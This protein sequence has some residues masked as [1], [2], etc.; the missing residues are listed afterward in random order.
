MSPRRRNSSRRGWPANLYERRGY[1]SWRNPITREEFGLGRDR[2]SAFA[3]AIEANLHIA[4]L[5]KKERLVD[6]LVSG[7]KKRTLGVWLERY[8]EILAERKLA[9]NTRRHYRSLA[10]RA[11]EI[12][13]ADTKLRAIT[14]L[15]VSEA[16][17]ALAKD[18]PRMAQ[19]LRS[20]LHES[21]REAVVQG[22]LDDNPVRTVRGPAVE[23]RRARLEFPV[24]MAV[25]ERTQTAWLRNAMAL[26]LVS[27]QRREDIALAEFADVHDGAW[28]V[29]QGKTGARIAIPLE[30]RLDVFGMSL[31]DVIRQCRRTGVVSPYLIHQTTARG[32]SPVGRRIWKD[33]IS[34][35][36]SAELEALGADFGGKE[37][38][39]FHEI[40]SLSARLYKAQGNVNVQELLGHKSA[41]TTMIY[42]DGRGE[43][44][45]V[46]VGTV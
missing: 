43:W 22:W 14:A 3:Q 6:R 5:L 41:Q 7:G 24:F 15:M 9:E 17:G 11:Q 21:F 30:L 45:R 38:P 44:I 4:G 39:T 29:E 35:R 1:Y 32:N 20:F 8:A 2:A 13:G 12:L 36:F 16:L 34:R 23:V 33:T 26:A 42:M 10:K 40:R 37:P 46:R 28:W 31:E 19:A 25:Y 18:H 27:A